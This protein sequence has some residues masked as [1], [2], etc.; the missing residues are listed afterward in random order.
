ME[1]KDGIINV[2][3]YIFWTKADIVKSYVYNYLKDKFFDSLIL[4]E[5]NKIDLIVLKENLPA[6]IQSTIITKDNNRNIVNHSIF[7][8][9]I[10]KQ[11]EDNIENY[12]KCWFFFDAEYYRYLN[13]SASNTSLN[14]DWLAKYVKED[15]LKIFTVKYNGLIK[16]LK[17]E[18]LEF[19]RKLSNTCKI[20]YDDDVRILNRNKIKIINNVLEG[21]NFKQNE[22]NM[23]IDKYNQRN[24]NERTFI[25][26]LRKKDDERKKLYANIVESIQNL[27]CINLI[28]NMNNEYKQDSKTRCRYLGIFKVNG[29]RGNANT[30]Q[31]IDKFNI[32]QF[33]PGYVRH[34]EEWNSIREMAFSD[35]GLRDYFY[36]K[37]H[38]LKTLR[39]Y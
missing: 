1:N 18:D 6:E 37:I 19:I 33:F 5:F 39:D 3:N 38:Q 24:S 8:N 27:K 25:E 22:I 28:L 29:D 20:G 15:K 23:F 13:E 32:C 11:I 9:Y 4:H 26:F 21:Y 10:R 34:R 12:D 14:M 17:Y 7:E 2:H 31:F 36:I 30:I 16:E 35:R